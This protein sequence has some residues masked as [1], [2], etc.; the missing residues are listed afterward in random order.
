MRVPEA[1]HCIF[2][3]NDAVIELLHS[4]HFM[5][6]S[7][8]RLSCVVSRITLVGSGTDDPFLALVELLKDE[9]ASDDGSI[10]KFLVAS[11]VRLSLA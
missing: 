7:I 10:N 8:C 4:G 11:G 2:V 3:G 1:T 6:A 9:T 5:Y